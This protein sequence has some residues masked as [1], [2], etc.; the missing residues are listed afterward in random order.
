MV[1]IKISKIVILNISTMEKVVN[2]QEFINKL[3]VNLRKG[4]NLTTLIS[5]KLNGKTE[6]EKFKFIKSLY[7]H[8][9]DHHVQYILGKTGIAT[10]HLNNKICASKLL[11][12]PLMSKED[13]HIFME[14]IKENSKEKVYLRD[15]LVC[16][17]MALYFF[18]FISYIEFCEITG[19]KI[20]DKKNEEWEKFMELGIDRYFLEASDEILKSLIEWIIKKRYEIGIQ[21]DFEEGKCIFY[22]I[23]QK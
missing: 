3:V 5:D 4:L 19:T 17:Y 15:L 13:I 7:P 2:N 16:Q 14:Y 11:G 22:F 18:A 1:S 8:K 9:E 12:Y 23:E 21:M 6:E 10:S 20:D